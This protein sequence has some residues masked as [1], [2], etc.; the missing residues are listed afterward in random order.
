MKVM[1]HYEEATKSKGKEPKSDQRER[2]RERK[3]ERKES[4][5]TP[6]LPSPQCINVLGP[7]S[8]SKRMKVR[9][10]DDTKHFKRK[11]A[12]PSFQRFISLEDDLGIC[13]HDQYSV[14]LSNTVSTGFAVLEESKLLMYAFTTR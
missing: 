3:H 1:I 4:Q 2:E 6:A 13:V 10:V 7:L 12:K 14:L 9:F 11:V 5:Q 8:V